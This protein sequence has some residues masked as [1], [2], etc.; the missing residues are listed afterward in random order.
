MSGGSYEF[1]FNHVAVSLTN[2]GTVVSQGLAHHKAC[3][4]WLARLK[5]CRDYKLTDSCPTAAH[6]THPPLNIE[7]ILYFEV[8]RVGRH[9]GSGEEGWT[10]ER[11]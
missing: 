4:P 1:N 7:E 3:I 2:F 9:E 10:Q 5:G 11:P 8:C 6:N